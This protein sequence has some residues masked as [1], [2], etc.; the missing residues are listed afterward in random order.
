MTIYLI[1]INSERNLKC[2]SSHEI[3]NKYG[4]EIPLINFKGK[5]VCDKPNN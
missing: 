3:V 4:R 2:K 1:T 5:I